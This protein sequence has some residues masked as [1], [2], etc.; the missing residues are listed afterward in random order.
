MRSVRRPA[1]TLLEATFSIVLVSALVVA[2]L[3]T[4]GASTVARQATTEAAAAK[5]LAASLMAEIVRQEYEEPEEIPLFGLELLE[6]VT[7]RL[8]FDD[9]DDFRNTSIS[10]LTYRDGAAIPGTSGWSYVVDV[11]RV[12]PNDFTIQSLSDTGVKRIDVRVRRGATEVATV[13]AIR[14]GNPAGSPLINALLE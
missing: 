14:T 6:T 3:Q 1:F 8:G 11:V 13:S 10:P 4:V 12:N 9:V 5:M 2:A 7:N